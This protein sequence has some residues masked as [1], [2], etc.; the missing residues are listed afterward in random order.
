MQSTYGRRVC[1]VRAISS[2]AEFASLFERDLFVVWLVAQGDTF[3]FQ[4]PGAR[5][6]GNGVA[7]APQPNGSAPMPLLGASSSRLGASPLEHMQRSQSLRVAE[8][9]AVPRLGASQHAA[10]AH[11]SLRFAAASSTHTSFVT[12]T[13]PSASALGAHAF[14]APAGGDTTDTRDIDEETAQ[15]IS[16]FLAYSMP[17][18]H[19][20]QESIAKHFLRVLH[21]GR[22]SACLVVNVNVIRPFSLDA[23]LL[24]V[25]RVAQ[26]DFDGAGHR[27]PGGCCEPLFRDARERVCFSIWQYSCKLRCSLR[28]S[29][30]ASPPSRCWSSQNELKR[31]RT[32]GDAMLSQELRAATQPKSASRAVATAGWGVRSESGVVSA[33]AL[34][35]CMLL[36]DHLHPLGAFQRASP[37]P[38]R[39]SQY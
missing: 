10:A 31:S 21:G 30:Q 33:R 2:R 3:Q 7:R 23:W 11:S 12:C 4:L 28:P 29:A 5:A 27:L 26:V 17:M 8:A 6:G 24:Y 16:F 1:T 34:V 32:S 20:A 13:P 15:R 38:V 14:A 9:Q 25:C 39:C 22:H 19:V 35:A 18:L 36:F 37:V